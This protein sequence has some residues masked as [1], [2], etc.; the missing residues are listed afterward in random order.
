MREFLSKHW[1]D[2]LRSAGLT[3]VASFSGFFLLQL[4]AFGGNIDY[5][6]LTNIAILETV[7][8]TLI[9]AALMALIPAVIE[10]IAKLRKR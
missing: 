6:S 5:S 10:T 4:T 1:K 2:Y 8:R 3:F 9:R 7:W